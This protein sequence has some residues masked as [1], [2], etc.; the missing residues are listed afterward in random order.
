MVRQ[1]FA[2][3]QYVGSNPILASQCARFV[4]IDVSRFS[5]ESSCVSDA[6]HAAWQVAT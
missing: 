2:K 4:S 1:R 3:P 5:V 6:A